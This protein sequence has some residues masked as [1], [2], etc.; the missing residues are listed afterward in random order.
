MPK[1][2]ARDHRA[3]D[4]AQPASRSEMT[5]SAIRRSRASISAKAGSATAMEFFPGAERQAR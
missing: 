5:L 2:R 4:L 1:P 3:A